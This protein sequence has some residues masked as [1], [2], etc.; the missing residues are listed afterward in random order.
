MGSPFDVAILDLTVR[1]GMGGRDCMRNLKTID[2][3]VKALVIS[4]Y[5]DD[6]AI[7]DHGHWGFAGAIRKPFRLDELSAALRR[8]MSAT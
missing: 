4:G 7:L 3:S 5:A 8:V 2:P 6:P 1:G